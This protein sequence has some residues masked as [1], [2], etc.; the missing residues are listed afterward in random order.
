M[1]ALVRELGGPD[2]ELMQVA[3]EWLTDPESSIRYSS[4]PGFMLEHITIT[5]RYMMNII[6]LFEQ[7]IRVDDIVL[8]LQVPGKTMEKTKLLALQGDAARDMLDAFQLVRTRY[9]NLY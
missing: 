5:R 1:C 2:E 4:T 6:N 7:R 3:Q 9:Y 8:T